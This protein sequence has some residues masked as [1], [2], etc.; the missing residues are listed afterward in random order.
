MSW[1]SYGR[2][3]R[4]LMMGWYLR[5]KPC[6]V[7]IVPD[8]HLED[9]ATPDIATPFAALPHPAPLDMVWEK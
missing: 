3:D 8:P 5:L 4:I 6:C 9:G 1:L 2:N 7:L